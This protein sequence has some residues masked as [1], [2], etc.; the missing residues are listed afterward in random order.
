MSRLC[1]REKGCSLRKDACTCD[2]QSGPAQSHIRI[3]GVIPAAPIPDNGSGYEGNILPVYGIVLQR[4]KFSAHTES[5]FKTV[6]RAAS[7]TF[8]RVG[9]VSNHER[10]GRVPRSPPTPGRIALPP[11]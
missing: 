6:K 9:S 10:I 11:V 5:C 8:T 3:D 1:F 4:E 7:L 2:S